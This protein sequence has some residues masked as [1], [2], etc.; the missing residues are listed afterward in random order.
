MRNK[1]KL[2]LSQVVANIPNDKP[3]IFWDTCALV[4]VA[5]I[6]HS[7]K[8]FTLQNLEQYEQIAQWIEDGRVI[9]LTSDV[10]SGEFDAHYSDE[11]A[12]MVAEQTK[13]KNQIKEFTQYLLNP[14][15]RNKIETTVDQLNIQNRLGMLTNKICKNT[16]VMRHEGEYVRFADYRTRKKMAPAYN[17]GE[18]KD[19]YIWG[20]FMAVLKR[21][22]PT[23]IC[24]FITTN[25]RDYMQ[26]NA[27]T[28]QIVAD[29]N[30]VNGNITFH[31]GE[32]Y[33]K[34]N[35]VLNP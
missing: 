14:A 23:N 16:T 3:I 2:W 9:S 21:L 35:H 12:A 32:L 11:Y 31:I 34:L 20:T 17:K 26:G 1:N 28:T 27:T 13:R 29:C 18:Y 19:C 25:P 30:S 22:H 6:P 4:D 24:Y 5:R 15:K 33:S 10:V 7:T 8:K